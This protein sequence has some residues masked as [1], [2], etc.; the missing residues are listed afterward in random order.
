MSTDPGE[1]TEA[2]EESDLPTAEQLLR[3][4]AI[5]KP[6]VLAL[7]DPPN[8]AALDRG[9]PSAFTYQEA[10]LT[11]DTLAAFFI[12]LELQP[13]DI[14]A[15][16]LPNFALSPLTLLG[17]WRAGLTVAAL[18]MLWR[19]HEIARVCAALEPKAL[20]GVSHFAGDTPMESLSAVAA[21]IASRHDSI[22]SRRRFARH[23]S[24]LS[25][26]IAKRAAS[27]ALDCWYTADSTSSRCSHFRDQP[28][29]MK[30]AARS[31]RSAAWVGCDPVAP[32]LLGEST[33]PC[34]KCCCQMRLTM[35]RAASGAASV[36]KARASSRRPLPC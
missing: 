24:R 15:M 32:K 22:S 8:R 6:N 9:T 36:T 18:P 20:I 7:F 4:R 34:P 31:S 25:G 23:N 35:T 1:E 26:S 29:A 12:E 19:V 5:Q 28:R 14:I 27:S 3:R 30:R 11:V 17:A 2:T 21:N 10:D 13:G 16:Q 33:S